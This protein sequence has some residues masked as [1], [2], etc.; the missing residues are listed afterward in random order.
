MKKADVSE[1]DEGQQW[2][3]TLW[4]RPAAPQTRKG[5]G[6]GSGKNDGTMIERIERS[7][8]ENR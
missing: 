6:D 3:P 4:A 1:A 5:R 2:R 7:E 8:D